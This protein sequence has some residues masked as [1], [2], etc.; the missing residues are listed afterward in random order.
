MNGDKTTQDIAWLERFS[1]HRCYEFP[2]KDQKKTCGK[3]KLVGHV[4]RKKAQR[5]WYWK[6]R[7]MKENIEEDNEEDNKED[8]EEDNKEDIK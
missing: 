5:C 1:L 6:G 4:E 7:S 3:V 2:K 8:R